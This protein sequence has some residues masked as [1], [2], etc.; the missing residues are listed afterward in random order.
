[1]ASFDA[2]TR[3]TYKNKWTRMILEREIPVTKNLF[4]NTHFLSSSTIQ[5][6]IERGLPNDSFSI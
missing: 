5:A 3:E 1:M 4:F 2:K 6:W